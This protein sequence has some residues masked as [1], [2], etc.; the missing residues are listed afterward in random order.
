MEAKKYQRVKNRAI[1]NQWDDNYGVRTPASCATGHRPEKL[2]ALSLSESSDWGWTGASTAVESLVNQPSIDFFSFC[3]HF[4]IPSRC[5]WISSQLVLLDAR[6]KHGYWI[7]RAP[8]LSRP[9]CR[10]QGS[11]VPIP[12]A[13]GPPVRSFSPSAPAS[14]S[15]LCTF[16]HLQ[17]LNLKPDL[18][19]QTAYPYRIHM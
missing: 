1:L 10:S 11:R 3:S 5:F 15:R 7:N 19:M 18:D 16:M 6:L 4:C 2:S 9:P 17:P 13:P 12:D 8:G 14:E